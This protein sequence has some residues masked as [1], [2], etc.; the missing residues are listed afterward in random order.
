MF[1]PNDLTVIRKEIA[2]ISSQLQ[3]ETASIARLR[4]TA[5]TRNDYKKETEMTVPWNLSA[6]LQLLRSPSC[7]ALNVAIL[8]QFHLNLALCKRT[9]QINSQLD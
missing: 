2:A 3:D 5:S 8:V 6:A 4:E 9:S 1:N 7:L